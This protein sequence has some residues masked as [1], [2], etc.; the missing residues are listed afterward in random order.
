MIGGHP[1]VITIPEAQFIADCIP[2]EAGRQEDLSGIVDGIADHWRFRIWGHQISPQRPGLAGS[3]TYADAI[4]WLVRDYAKIH[5]RADA[6]VWVDHQPGHGQFLARLNDHFP[7]LRVIHVVR[8][9]RAVAASLLP[10]D[11]GPNEIHSAAYF[12]EQRIAWCLAAAEFLGKDRVLLLKYEDAVRSPETSMRKVADFL[13]IAYH[14]DMARG[15]G[16]AVPSFTVEQHRLVG[17]LPDPSRIN[18]W[19]KKLTGRQIEIF[20]AITGD[21]LVYFGYELM[22]G[23]KPR[24]ITL[25]E[26][27]ALT[28]RGQLKAAWHNWQFERRK[29]KFAK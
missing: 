23:R 9:G 17:S 21:M 16:L 7:D 14:P 5:G 11:W 19:R 26:K 2:A 24:P 20:E 15:I 8:D 28:A 18:D 1:D 13:R 22:S 4:R 25:R 10:L 6:S 12:W 29:R 3:G 27:V